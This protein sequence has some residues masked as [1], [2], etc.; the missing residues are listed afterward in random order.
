MG[1]APRGNGTFGNTGIGGT[2][3]VVDRTVFVPRATVVDDKLM[4]VSFNARSA[5]TGTVIIAQP[6]MNGTVVVSAT[7]IAIYP[8]TGG[9]RAGFQ[10][11]NL[12][13]DPEF[14]DHIY[15]HGSL[16][17]IFCPDF[18]MAYR[19]GATGSGTARYA[20]GA[21]VL[22]VSKAVDYYPASQPAI[23]YTVFTVAETLEDRI[24][25]LGNGSGGKGKASP[26]TPGNSLYRWRAKVSSILSGYTVAQARAM[27]IGSSSCD[28][29]T[30]PNEFVRIQGPLIGGQ[31]ATG[32]ISTG[33]EGRWDSLT[34]TH[35]GTWD[36]IDMDL[37]GGLLGLDGYARTCAT[38]GG[39]R[40]VQNIRGQ[41]LRLYVANN[42]AAFTY[43]L[44]GGAATSVTTS[45]SG[46][47]RA[48]DLTL[49]A[50][51]NQLVITHVSGTL[52]WLGE[53]A[54]TSSPSGLIVHKCGNRGSTTG[55]WEALAPLL[56]PYLAAA[57]PDVAIVY[58]GND[59]TAGL[60][61]KIM[62]ERMDVFLQQFYNTVPDCAIVLVSQPITGSLSD[63]AIAPQEYVNAYVNYAKTNAMVEHLDFYNSYGAYDGE[64]A[65]G[66][67]LPDGNIHQ[68]PAGAY[69]MMKEL[70][71]LLL[72]TAG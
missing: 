28:Y 40:T 43:A 46:T 9:V 34:R 16:V 8:I 10:T 1:T 68:S 38:V 20:T 42:G 4:S 53:M 48:I 52:R 62:M 60:D 32:W 47:V 45:T 2:A 69:R 6:V 13:D 24:A 7:P 11:F 36:V 50:G 31:I 15:P 67:F 21:P 29:P 65:L 23:Q 3:G 56:P 54:E 58:L 63:Y 70:D 35:S 51:N 25:A 12:P 44:N 33:A 41:T 26:A 64:A 71:R 14:P 49:A 66:Q 55:Q 72:R 61:P 22:G 57:Q 19:N 17:G 37:S 39:A 18:V 30:L 5:G 59:R 27:F